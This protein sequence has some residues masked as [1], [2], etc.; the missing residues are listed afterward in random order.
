MFVAG[1]LFTFSKCMYLES[2]RQTMLK[3]MKISSSLKFCIQSFLS[4][5]GFVCENHHYLR[6]PL[7]AAPEKIYL[8]QTMFHH[9][10]WMDNQHCIVIY[11]S[12][13]YDI[14]HTTQLSLNQNN[15]D[16]CCVG[17]EWKFHHISRVW[18]FLPNKEMKT[19]L[20]Y[21]DD[22]WELI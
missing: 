2:H 12:N 14:N 17:S 15:L 16:L 22:Q 5:E 8:V 19:R 6:D 20:K 10:N 11:N 21:Y 3:V 13:L 18:V 9:N 4:C 7:D 1:A